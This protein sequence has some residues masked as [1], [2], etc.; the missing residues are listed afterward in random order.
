MISHAPA[1]P[2]CGVNLVTTYQLD[3]LGRTVEQTDPDGDVTFTVY[4]DPLQ[5][6]RTYTGWMYSVLPASVKIVKPGGEQGRGWGSWRMLAPGGGG[7]GSRPR[8]SHDTGRCCHAGRRHG[9]P[10]AST[11]GYC[12]RYVLKRLCRA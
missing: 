1:R 2:A 9:S 8:Q 3:D 4:D 10:T 11:A 5:E 6:F 7:D 12:C